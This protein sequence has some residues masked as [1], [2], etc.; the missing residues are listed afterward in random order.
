MSLKA[1]CA[2]F[3]LPES[4]TD[5]QVLAH[6]KHLTAEHSLV[7]ADA[8]KSGAE[9]ANLQKAL[10]AKEAALPDPAKYVPFGVFEAT[11]SE[12]AA[13]K[14]KAAKETAAA[15]AE[16][17]VKAGKVSP[18]MAEWA[19]DYASKDPD[20]FRAYLDKAPA[21]VSGAPPADAKAKASAAAPGAGN[22]GKLDAVEKAVCRA[23]G[24]AEEDYIKARDAS[25]GAKGEE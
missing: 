21:I 4:A 13:L 23:A 15:L 14:A 24:I 22:P 6:A 1:L 2:V 5:E 12:L 7:K 8:A 9:V 17:G 20:G 10:A 11:A 25:G 16:E 18:A 19:K 3:G